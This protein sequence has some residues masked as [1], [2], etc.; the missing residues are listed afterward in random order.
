M[1]PLDRSV[2]TPTDEPSSIGKQKKYP[3]GKG[4]KDEGG[5]R[6]STEGYSS[7]D[8]DGGHHQCTD[9]VT[10]LG[11]VCEKMTKRVQFAR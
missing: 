8:R 7:I 2:E 11:L 9:R 6:K 10:V 4:Q 1:T 5:R 3:L